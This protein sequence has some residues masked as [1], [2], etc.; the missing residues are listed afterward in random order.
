M[1]SARKVS[2]RWYSS[3]YVGIF[4]SNQ[5]EIIANEHPVVRG[6]H[7]HGAPGRGRGQEPSAIGRQFGDA[8]IQ[9]DMKHLPFTVVEAA[10]ANL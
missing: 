8:T 7:G 6:V 4:R 9:A 2:A 10:A 3:T 5:V 1:S